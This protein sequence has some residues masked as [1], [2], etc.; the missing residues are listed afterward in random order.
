MKLLALAIVVLLIVISL[1]TF[2]LATQERSPVRV[3]CVGDSITQGTGYPV[4]LWGLLG[5]NYVVGDF[6]VGGA[7][8]ALNSGNSYLDS[9]AFQV[10]KDFQPHI[11]I[12]MLG[13][14][15]AQLNLN[16][17]NQTFISDYTTLVAEIKSFTSKP[18]VWIV[19]PPPVFPNDSDLDPESFRQNIIPSI[20]QVA[21]QMNLR[22]IDVYTPLSSHQEYFLE[23][24]VHPNVEGAQAIAN[25][26]FNALSS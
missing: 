15:D 17:T 16:Q 5:S 10:A 8:V 2:M 7:T 9:T 26:I 4:E 18:E 14:N 13:T 25:I 1:E 20:S 11:V 22:L 21:N 3:A 12:V 23:D 6:G 19:K 24:G